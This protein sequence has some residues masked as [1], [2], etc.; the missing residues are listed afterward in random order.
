MLRSWTSEELD[1]A[2]KLQAAGLTAPEV[3]KAIGRSESA[4][5]LKLFKCGYSSRTRYDAMSDVAEPCPEP[6]PE[7]A[8]VDDLEQAHLLLE[9]REQQIA[10]RR[11]RAEAIERAQR[12]R[13]LA[14][15][16]EVLRDCRLDLRYTPPVPQQKDEAHSALLCFGD[17]HFGLV[18]DPLQHEPHGRILYNPAVAV[19]RLALLESEVISLLAKGPPLDEM[20]IL[21]LGDI[22]EGALQ[23]GNEREDTWLVSRQFTLAVSLLAQFLTRLAS[24]VPRVRCFGVSGNH[25]RLH[26][27]RRMPTVGRESNADHLVYQSLRMITQAARCPNIEWDLRESP[28]QIIELK[29]VR[30]HA[31]HGDQYRGGDYGVNGAKKEVFNCVLRGM[32]SGKFPDLW[33]YADEHN[34]LQLPAAGTAQII[35]NGSLCGDAGGYGENFAPISASQS[36]IWICPRRGKVMQ[37]DIRLDDAV[38]TTP[39]PYELPAPLAQMVT[40]YANTARTTH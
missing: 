22:L 24:H 17:S 36:L 30:I 23:H 29:G 37:A 28:R 31:A 18:S 32:Q 8:F 14:V 34:A 27:Q 4:L 9:T 1:R 21:F 38:P 25:G 3:A 6:L 16:G 15:F 11:Q 10:A 5:R 33:I 13:L 2:L 35:C 26:G 12:E 39:L 20:C 7:S 40:T 19:A